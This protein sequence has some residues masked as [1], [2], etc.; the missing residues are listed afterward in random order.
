[1]LI[2]DPDWIEYKDNGFE[3]VSYHGRKKSPYEG[4]TWAADE[5]VHFRLANPLNPFW[6]M[7]PIQAAYRA[8]DID[9]KIIEWWMNTLENGCKKDMLF[10]FK[11]DLTDT[12]FKRVRS[13]IDQQVSGFRN[14]R[15]YMILGH[16]A[17]V[18]FLNMAPAEL[19]FSK[20]RE[21]SSQEIMGIF[22]VPP[23]I[24]GDL[25]HSTYNNIKEARQ[26][27]WLDTIMPLLNDLSAIFSKNLLENFK[28]DP[29]IY[30]ISYDATEVEALQR[31]GF[32]Q[33]EAI[34]KMVN[35]GVP[36]NTA[37]KYYRIQIPEVEGGDIGYMSHNLV[38]LGF[39]NEDLKDK[40]VSENDNDQQPDSPEADSSSKA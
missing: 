24:I 31:L 40:K 17:E 4:N 22:R 3:I 27:F 38:P 35:I 9:S 8:V 10:R 30:E 25:S 20:S 26:S 16:E 21:K 2:L 32:E 12:Q 6:G 14:G 1:M 19:D 29:M 15:G 18:S 28:L 13:L 39:Y 33:W 36:L 11:H 7:S 34:S 23:P 5:I 37:V